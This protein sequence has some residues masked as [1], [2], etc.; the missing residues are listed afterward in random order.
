MTSARLTLRGLDLETH[1]RTPA[2]RQ[3]Y[4]TTMFEMIAP[5]YDRFTGAFSFGMDAAWKRELLGAIKTDLPTDATVLDLACG[6]GDLAA[7]LARLVPDGRVLGLD[8]APTMVACARQRSGQ[9]ANL[10]FV[11]GDMMR[12]DLPEASQDL[13]TIGYGLRNVPDHRAA[14]REIHRVLRPG[15]RLAN[16]DFA[17]PE[18][19][20]W[21]TLYLWYLR[22]M[23]DL[24]GWLWHGEPEVYGY[25]SRSIAHFVTVRQLAEDLR[26]TGFGILYESPKLNGGVCLHLARKA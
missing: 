21:R 18:P 16:L 13:V 9:V 8:A 4:V 23:G 22:A 20:W 3:R 24:Y 10:D 7:A 12:L 2:I 5:T 25:I 19:G 17:L 14:L 11:I 1:L 15:G 26:E 6:T